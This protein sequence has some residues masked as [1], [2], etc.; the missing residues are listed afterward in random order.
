MY[1]NGKGGLKIFVIGASQGN[2]GGVIEFPL[3]MY[4][5]MTT[6]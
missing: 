5:L 3:G 6:Y 1:K 2:F 4:Y